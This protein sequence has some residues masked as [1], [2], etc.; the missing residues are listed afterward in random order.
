MK[1]IIF[2]GRGGQGVVIASRLLAEAAFKEGKNV[3]SFP[4]FGVER[5]GAPVMAYTRISS[6]KIR[7]RGPV[8]KADYAVVLDSTLLENIEITKGLKKKGSI[9]INTAFSGNSFLS[10]KKFKVFTFD[11]SAMAEKHRL[12]SESA[13]IVNT[14]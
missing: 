1:E 14:S 10:M 4:F 6:G 7:K 11:A 2:Y 12:G 13:P 9:I 5:R 3:Q 8:N